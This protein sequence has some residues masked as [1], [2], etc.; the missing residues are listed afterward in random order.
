M[1]QNGNATAW[2]N[3]RFF[4]ILYGQFLIFYTR[5][6]GIN[7]ENKKKEKRIFFFQNFVG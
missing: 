5:A 7:R 4:I 1:V 3:T 6:S 2:K